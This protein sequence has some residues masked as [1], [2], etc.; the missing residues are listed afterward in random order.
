M[1]ATGPLLRSAGM[2]SMEPR[3]QFA[4][5]TRNTAE[6]VPEAELLDKL[7]RSAQDARPL[8]VKLGLD[9]T[10]PDVTLGWA[11]VLRKLREFQDLGHVPVLIVGDFTARVGDP[12]GRSETRPRLEASVVR[13]HGE[14][15]LE[16][17]WKILNRD[18]TEVRYNA[19]WLAS[20]GMEDILSLTS[21]STVARMLER[22]D[23]AKRF[24]ENKPIS[25]MEFLYP[26]LQAQD[27]VAVRADVE[28]G[29]TDQKF[30][31]LLGRELQRASGQEPQVAFTMPLLIGLD[32]VNKMS[33]S[34]GNYVG[35]G[36]RPEEMFGKLMSLP[37]EQIVPYLRLCTAPPDDDIRA[38]EA[39]LA[40]GSRHPNREKRRMAREIVSLYHGPDA[41]ARAESAFD[42]VF[43]HHELPADIPEVVFPAELLGERRVWLPRLLALLGMAT[44]NGDARRL[45]LSGAVRLDGEPLRDPVQEF[46]PEELSGRVLQVGRRH[47]VR[48]APSR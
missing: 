24:E 36:E 9:P 15:L 16:Q 25:I 2:A 31:L 3:A 12:S 27:S 17:F 29:G 40:D 8:R 47:F 33:Q 1:I 34:L 43:K 21:S 11:V 41:A 45:M 44:S 23:F 48:I 28:L 37:D 42:R 5:L 39:G 46:A 6:V 20:M 22:D 4:F 10:A 30:N 18:R 38:L 14:R 7:E 19:E 13:A 26:L 35:I 32:G